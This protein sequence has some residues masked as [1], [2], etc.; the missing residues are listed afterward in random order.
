MHSLRPSALQLCT[1]AAFISEEGADLFPIETEV[2]EIDFTM[3]LHKIYDGILVELADCLRPL[4]L[5][6][7]CLHLTRE[8]FPELEEC[9]NSS[10]GSYSSFVSGDSKDS[11]DLED[12]DAD[13]VSGPSRRSMTD[14]T[15]Y[16]TVRDYLEGVDVEAYVRS[17]ADSIPT[18]EE[19]RILFLDPT[20]GSWGKELTF[21]A[22]V[23]QKDG[24]PT[25]LQRFDETKDMAIACTG[26]EY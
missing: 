26:L 7:L 12:N 8:D 2:Y 1:D 15:A 4:P 11:E 13:S 10:D 3:T 21:H 9:D 22:Q 6:R 24:V 20:G 17:L 16:A 14:N 5:K 23:I 25:K 18:L 19:I